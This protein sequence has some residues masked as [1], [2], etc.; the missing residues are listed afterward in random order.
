MSTRTTRLALV[1]ATVAALLSATAGTA[2]AVERRDVTPQRWARAVCTA[3]NTWLET[4]PLVDMKTGETAN[5]L[6]AGDTTT[7][8]AQARLVAQYRKAGAASDRLVAAVAAAGTPAID[9]GRAIATRFRATVQDL[10]SAYAEATSAMAKLPKHAA[11]DEVAA[12]QRRASDAI[13]VVGDPLEE[14]EANPELAPVMNATTSCS[15]V[16]EFYHAVVSLDLAVGDCF[17]DNTEAI[18]CDE[19]HAGEV[20]FVGQH[21]APAGAPFPGD[22][23]IEA[24]VDA[25]CLAAFSAYVGIDLDASR[26]DL[27]WYS[28]EADGWADGDREIVCEVEN[29]DTSPITGSLR[30]SA[31]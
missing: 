12:I 31:Q 15:D 3:V 13:T 11:D 2:T 23:G 28:P 10:Q 30:G 18:A 17:D 22:D 14:L 1:A 8:A 27:G 4:A 20:V 7:T 9:D 29:V 6:V 19:P 26:Y 21:E 25:H 24:W 5:L 16:H